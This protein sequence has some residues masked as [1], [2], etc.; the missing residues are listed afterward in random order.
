M[1]NCIL[2]QHCNVEKLLYFTDVGRAILARLRADRE[3]ATA[4]RGLDNSG[5]D[6]G[7]ITLG[8]LVLWTGDLSAPRH[9]APSQNNINSTASHFF[10][11]WQHFRPNSKV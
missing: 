2:T 7:A 8:I 5:T 4:E 1:K 3:C 10:L 6:D 9:P 11:C